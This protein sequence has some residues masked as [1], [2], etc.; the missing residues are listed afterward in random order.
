VL[1]AIVKA[2][3]ASLD[4]PDV[5]GFQEAW[6]DFKKELLYNYSINLNSRIS[7]AMEASGRKTKPK[8]MSMIHDEE[9]SRCI[10]TAT[11]LCNQHGVD[12]SEII[13]K[14]KN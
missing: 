12:I 2:Y 4:I 14:Y 9:L 13:S 11:A 10:S 3:G 5:N 7:K 1:E 8:T 6:R